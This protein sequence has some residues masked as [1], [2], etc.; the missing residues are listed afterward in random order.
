LDID[1]YEPVDE[2]YDFCETARVADFF[3]YYDEG[4]TIGM[5]NNVGTA[6]PD[7]FY[8]FYNPV[9]ANVNLVVC[10][11]TFDARVQVIEYCTGGFLDDTDDGCFLGADLTVYPLPVGEFHVI[12]EGTS[13]L[14]MG[15]FS[16]EIGP[17]FPDCPVPQDLVI[18][19]VANQPFLDWEDVPEAS[20]YMVYAANSPAE[21]YE[22][23]DSAFFS[24]YADPA[25]YAAAK[26]MYRVTTVC[27]WGE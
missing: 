23:L 26:R 16:I 15:F 6:A 12:V 14:E 18:Y 9:E 8:R 2:D 7:V 20:Y 27:P 19:S 17:D 21:P 13:A 1:C 4:S 24:Y 25:G 3:P 22:H 5:S 11:E 10:T